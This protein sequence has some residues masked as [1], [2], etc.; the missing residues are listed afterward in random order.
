MS[1]GGICRWGKD[2]DEGAEG[3]WDKEGVSSNGRFKR[4]IT[5]SQP[6]DLYSRAPL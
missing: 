1:K 2:Q 5:Q 4:G 6:L 3:G